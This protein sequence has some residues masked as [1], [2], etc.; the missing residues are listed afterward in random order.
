M[1][2]AIVYWL[3]LG[4]LR[5]PWAGFVFGAAWWG[6]F[7]ALLGPMIGAVPPL[8]TIGWDSIVTDLCLYL[9]WGLFIGFSIAFELHD[10]WQREPKNKAAEGTPQPSS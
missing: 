3:A 7:Y 8:R 1:V 9:I 6:L 4:K 2:A 10:E 5:G